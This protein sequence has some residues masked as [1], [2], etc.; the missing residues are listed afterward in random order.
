MWTMHWMLSSLNDSLSQNFDIPSRLCRCRD[1]SSC[2]LVVYILRRR[3]TGHLPPAGQCLTLCIWLYHRVKSIKQILPKTA[4]VCQRLRTTFLSSLLVALH[5]VQWGK[6]GLC[7]DPLRGV[8]VC[9]P[10]DHG[11]VCAGH[12]RDVQRSEQVWLHWW[13]YITLVKLCLLGKDPFYC[14]VS[15]LETYLENN[16]VRWT[17]M[18]IFH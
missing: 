6:R 13:Q 12:H 7:W 8:R 1:C 9:S 3:P 4:V 17:F 15:H 2:C 5:A 16:W 18:G 14:T 10:N 11:S